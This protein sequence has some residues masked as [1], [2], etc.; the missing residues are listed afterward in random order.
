LLV[1]STKNEKKSLAGGGNLSTWSDLYQKVGGG[2][3]LARQRCLVAKTILLKKEGGNLDEPNSRQRKQ[4]G[5]E[6][7][8]SV[9]TG[10]GGFQGTLQ[11]HRKYGKGSGGRSGWMAKR[12]QEEVGEA[13]PRKMGAIKNRVSQKK[14]CTR[15]MGPLLKETSTTLEGWRGGG[16]LALSV[17]KKFSKVWKHSHV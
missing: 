6:R 14:K 1:P 15:E 3:Q 2:S 4:V 5:I 12:E 10:N 8:W 11:D 7:N 17:L 9:L 16:K 13:A